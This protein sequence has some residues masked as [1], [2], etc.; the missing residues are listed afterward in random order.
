MRVQPHLPRSPFTATAIAAWGAALCVCRA[1]TRPAPPEPRIRMSVS[2]ERTAPSE[3]LDRHRNR[4]QAEPGDARPPLGVDE[5]EPCGDEEQAYGR[6]GVSVQPTLKTGDER[7]DARD[8][9]ERDE[10][11]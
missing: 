4:D 9:Y 2:S 3:H 10:R 7:H 5:E 6:S 8:R 11:N 1:A